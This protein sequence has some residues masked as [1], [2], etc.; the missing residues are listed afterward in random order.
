MRRVLYI[1]HRVPFPPDKGERL[2]A[3]HQ[4]KALSARYELT[5]A[6]L[7]HSQGDLTAADGLRGCAR[8]VIVGKAGGLAG[9]VRGA[10]SLAAGRSVTEGY[11]RSR[12]LERQL[13]ALS[14]QAPFDLAI[15]YSSSVLPALLR[16]NAKARVMDLIDVDSA[17][18]GDYARAAGGIRGSLYRLESHRVAAL[19]RRAL[20]QC[21]AVVLTS[22]QEAALLDA[23]M[24]K[25]KIL[26]IG[27]GVDL[28]YFRPAQP[29][30][31][32]GRT[33]VFTGT[34]D[35]R[36][37]VEAVAW[38]V[39]QVWPAVRAARGDA[40]FI[41]VG[42][43]PAAAVR[44]LA[45]EPGVE[46][47][48][49]V[50]DVR[51]FL[52]QA[53]VAVVP[54]HIARGIQN[55][56]LEAMAMG[57]AVVASPQAMEGLDVTAG[58]EVLCADAEPK[59]IAHLRRLLMCPEERIGLGRLARQCVEARYTWTARLAGLMNLAES[60]MEGSGAAAGAESPVL[61]AKSE[62]TSS[63]ATAWPQVSTVAR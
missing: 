29:A 4:I 34:M 12:S 43:D 18:W 47:T 13:E 49:Q 55:K 40:R 27:N 30:G 25:S 61:V 14:G 28:E 31:G 24:H 23:G 38:F 48:G 3:Y 8:K 56:V 19:E 36:P 62:Q 26:P 20:E 45:R 57:A 51:P 10:A 44:R 41:I 15:G 42:R 58:R 9:L 50:P 7:A 52:A 46:V 16:A 5:V 60:L 59:W 11:F 21:Q 33:I 17:K 63:A 35:Y 22:P 54:L 32:D 1:A 39:R 37:N 53:A 6:A 2:R